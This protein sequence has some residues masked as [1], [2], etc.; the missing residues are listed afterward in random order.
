MYDL[1]CERG[2]PTNAP[3]DIFHT[4]GRPF[5]ALSVFHSI[6]APQLAS[7]MSP[8]LSNRAV[9]VD[10]ENYPDVQPLLGKQEEKDTSSSRDSNAIL[11]ESVG[12]KKRATTFTNGFTISSHS[13]TF[14]YLSSPFSC[15]S[16]H[17]C[18]ASV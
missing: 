8:M 15:I 9:L 11:Q 6:R 7:A 18:V 16:K 1:L 2:T 13:L 17:Q 14:P 10:E 12:Q 3:I 4:R 5:T